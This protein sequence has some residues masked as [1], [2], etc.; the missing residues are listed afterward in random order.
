MRVVPN[1]KEINTVLK[2]VL[3]SAFIGFSIAVL[4]VACEDEYYVGK[5]REEVYR[6]LFEI[7]SLVMTIK[8]QVD[9]LDSF[10][11]NAQRINNGHE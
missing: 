9:S 8:M 10:Y 4:F 11:T 6:S 1:W 3:I 7:D 5:N 2:V